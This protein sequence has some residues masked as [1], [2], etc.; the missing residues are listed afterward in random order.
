MDKKEIIII[1]LK[2][3]IYMCTLIL[4]A[5]GVAA[6][7]SCSVQ[8]DVSVNGKATIVTTDTTYI[9]HNGYIIYPKK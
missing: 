6:M 8:R 1:T 5:L 7:T 2:V 4:A 3:V 9:N